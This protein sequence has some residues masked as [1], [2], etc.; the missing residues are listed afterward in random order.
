MKAANHK[1]RTSRKRDPELLALV[2]ANIRRFREEKGWTQEDL[3][4]RV[5]WDSKTMVS[6]LENRQTGVGPQTLRK[7]AI[8]FGK[9]PSEFFQR[10]PSPE[11]HEARNMVQT[12]L[13]ELGGE[14]DRRTADG[15]PLQPISIEYKNAFPFTSLVRES[16][17]I[18]GEHKKILLPKWPAGRE[19][20]NLIWA[21]VD[22]ETSTPHLEFGDV[23][24]IDRDDQPDL[25][26]TRPDGVYAVRLEKGVRLCRVEIR[27]HLLALH[28]VH[29]KYV[30]GEVIDSEE[31]I[32]LDLRAH[33]SAIIGRVLWVLKPL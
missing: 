10:T 7:L 21:Y 2:A 26:K 18:Y 16:P 3:R 4:E 23:L 11:S 22:D 32:T 6:Q 28:D 15:Q 31:P 14:E 29:K 30:S 27:G 33:P 25:T 8:A 24:C 13:A 20:H 17:E 1:K 9:D 5:K 19:K 12:T